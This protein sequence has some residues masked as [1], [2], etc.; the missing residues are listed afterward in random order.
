MRLHPRQQ[1]GQVKRVQV[2][3]LDDIGIARGDEMEQLP[4]QLRLLADQ[5]VG[6]ALVVRDADHEDAR[7]LAVRVQRSGLDVHLHALQVIKR[8]ALERA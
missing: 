1:I 7:A 2:V 8:H 4:Q 5:H 6:Q 3:P